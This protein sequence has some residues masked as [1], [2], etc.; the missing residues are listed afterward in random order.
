MSEL[1]IYIKQYVDAKDE[2]WKLTNSSPCKKLH[3]LHKTPL[4][5]SK[6]LEI[7]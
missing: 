3:N 1:A 5:K 6:S 2:L 7:L 4:R